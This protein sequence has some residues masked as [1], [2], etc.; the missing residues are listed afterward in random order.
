MSAIAGIYQLDD[1][2]VGRDALEAMTEVVSYRGPDG[3]GYWTEGPLGLAHLQ[4]RTTPESYREAQPVVA[5]HGTYAITLDGRIDNRDHLIRDLRPLGRARMDSTDPELLLQAYITWGRQCVRRIVGDFSFAIWDG[6]RRQLFCARDPVGTRVLYYYSDGNRFICGTEIKQLL[7]Q[8]GVPRELD[9]ITMGLFLCSCWGDGQQT[10]YRGVQRLL[11]GHTLTV[12]AG[13][14]KLE[15]YWAPDPAD[16]PPLRNDEEYVE[17]LLGLLRKAVRS[18]LRSASPVALSLSGGLDSGSIA[19]IAGELRKEHPDLCP[20]FRAY[21]YSFGEHKG[22]DA[23]DIVEAVATCSGT[24]LE[25]IDIG[26]QWA[27]KEWDG[28]MALMDEPFELPYEALHRRAL[29]AVKQDGVR[30]I[31][32]GEGGDDLFDVGPQLHIRDW[33]RRLRFGAIL[34]ELKNAEGSYRRYVLRA[35]LRS[36]IPMTFR[37]MLR[38]TKQEIPFWIDPDFAKRKELVERLQTLQPSP[39][40]ANSYEE[41]VRAELRY[42]GRSVATLSCD[43]LYAECGIE[44]RHSFWDRRVV[45]FL[46]RIPPERKSRKGISKVL[47]RRAMREKLPQAVWRPGRKT[48][49]ISLFEEGLK[50]RE[51]PR[52]RAM[53]KDSHLAKLG[54]V[55]KA[56]LEQAFEMYLQGEDRARGPLYWALVSER[57]LRRRFL[58]ASA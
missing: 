43:R 47:L 12:S 40:W 52:L 53:L 13:N 28:G 57:W 30:V 24:P 10:F 15:R 25:W 18:R 39:S 29:R 23:P 49:F 45:E 50:N 41:S 51:A 8:P 11:G 6:V 14:L 46:V 19:V 20:N 56:A 1:R 7:T 3:V 35:I 27:L 32:T 21:S 33:A 4:L 48:S 9:E 42:V 31:L 54:V 22:A 55:D 17:E 44:A 26:N 2:P 36:L 38:R 37:A 16:H 34:S 58:V 5:S